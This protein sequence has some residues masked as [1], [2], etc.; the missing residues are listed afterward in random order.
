MYKIVISNKYGGGSTTDYI[1]FDKEEFTT[2]DLTDAIDCILND[3]DVIEIYEIKLDKILT[4][5]INGEPTDCNKNDVEM[6][7]K[8]EF[9]DWETMKYGSW[10]QYGR[11]LD[12][13]KRKYE[14]GLYREPMDDD[15]EYAGTYTLQVFD[16]DDVILCITAF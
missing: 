13:E 4:T 8:E 11:I 9:P 5:I 10:S 15:E 2:K 12:T 3:C 7:V 16:G 1:E 6:L 14:V